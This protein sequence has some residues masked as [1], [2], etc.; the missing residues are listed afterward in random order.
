MPSASSVICTQQRTKFPTSRSLGVGCFFERMLPHSEVLISQRLHHLPLY[1]VH[2]VRC[3]LSVPLPEQSL[4]ENH[5][6]EYLYHRIRQ[7]K[8]QSLCPLHCSVRVRHH[9]LQRFHPMFPKQYYCLNGSIP[10]EHL[11]QGQVHPELNFSFQKGQSPDFG[12]G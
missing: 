6:H 10:S 7:G 1:V 12:Y 4:R 11:N 8:L 3:R 9:P 5:S 2:R